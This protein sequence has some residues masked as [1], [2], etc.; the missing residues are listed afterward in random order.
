M[1]NYAGKSELTKLS[2][3]ADASPIVPFN[4]GQR[5][6]QGFSITFDRMYA[7]FQDKLNLEYQRMAEMHAASL[8][9]NL[10]ANVQRKEDSIAEMQTEIEQ[11][12]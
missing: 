10:T 7:E 12:D 3:A 6:I 11:Q 1:S 9:E 8:H 5:L 2:R 4:E